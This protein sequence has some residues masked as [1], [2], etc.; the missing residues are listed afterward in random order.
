MV[1]KFHGHRWGPCVPTSRQASARAARLLLAVGAA[2]GLA[3]PAAHATLLVDE[4]FNY[5]TLANG[6]NMNG[7]TATGLGLSGNYTVGDGHPG[8]SAGTFVYQTTGL[9]LGS[10]SVSGGSVAMQGNAGYNATLSAP[11]SATTSAS[12]LYGSYL[13]SLSSV[14]GNESAGALIGPISGYDNNSLIEPLAQAYGTASYG[15][16]GGAAALAS[17]SV[18]TYL[19]GS[20]QTAGTTYIALF[21]VSGV[22]ASSGTATISEWILNASQYD[23]FASNGDLTAS[24]LNAAGTGTAA[25]NVLQSGA[26]SGTPSDYPGLTGQY[27]D[28]YGAATAPA[29]SMTFA[30]YRLSDASLAEAAPLATTP[31]PDPLALLVA[32]GAGLLIFGRRLAI[33]RRA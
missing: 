3:A 4:G 9:S 22:G 17:K 20:G 29:T 10:L 24:A 7:I 30:D 5:P 19:S 12:T 27:L 33:R 2:L 11:I 25:T 18:F 8:S 26:A 6:A 13:F 15:V 32:G 16:P 31:E 28:F 23:Q 21:Q 1:T 14:G